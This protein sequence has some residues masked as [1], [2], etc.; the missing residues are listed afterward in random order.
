MK[1][2]RWA[3]ALCLLAAAAGCALPQH[4]DVIDVSK[5]AVTWSEASNVVSHFNTQV[6]AA[7]AAYDLRALRTVEGGSL[8]NLDAAA[9]FARE[10]L[11]MRTSATHLDGT[12]TIVAGSFSRYPLW[13][14]AWGE[15]YGDRQRVAG[16]FAKTSSTA[17]WR[18][19]AAP[20]LAASTAPPR[21]ATSPEG[22]AVL[23]PPTQGSGRLVSPQALVGRYT[24]V[25]ADPEAPYSEDFADDAFLTSI[26]A[27]QAAQPDSEV[28]FTQTWSAE[29]V[30][31][32]L[33][34]TDGGTLVFATV[35]RTDSYRVLGKHALTWRGS[36]AAAYFPHP[37]HRR[38]TLTYDHQ[39]LFWQPAHGKPVVIGQYGGLVAATGG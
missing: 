34:L 7:S 2:T 18:L 14:V 39:L 37:V 16:V 9:L 26:R 21:V 23:V 28:A 31:F 25:L 22:S 32:A 36:P 27:V 8:Y 11:G 33:R 1:R 15:V 38:A 19:S 12:T 13:F 4:K 30:E 17:P 10:Q 24:Q 6:D 20:R 3:A 35:V 29:P 5:K